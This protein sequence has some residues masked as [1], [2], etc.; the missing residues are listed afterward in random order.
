MTASSASALPS[1]LA[2]PIRSEKYLNESINSDDPLNSSYDSINRS[3]SSDPM[4]VRDKNDNEKEDDKGDHYS[5]DSAST[6]ST[7]GRKMGKRSMRGTLKGSVRLQEKLKKMEE[8]R[9]QK[10]K[11]GE[12][13]PGLD[14]GFS[15]SLEKVDEVYGVQVQEY[16]KYH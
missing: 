9:I 16:K 11:S 7:I 3:T 13:V 5:F 14:Q 15:G 8:E 4:V 6:S 12:Y 10:V 1:P 2:S